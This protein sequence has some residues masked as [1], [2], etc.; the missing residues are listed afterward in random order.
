MYRN[1]IDCGN[2]Q[3][4]TWTWATWTWSTW[5]W[6][7]SFQTTCNYTSLWTYIPKCYINTDITST[8]CQKTVSV[9]GTSSSS[10]SS[11]WG[12]SCTK[13]EISKNTSTWTWLTSQITCYGNSKARRYKID[14]GNGQEIIWDGELEAWHYGTKFSWTCNYVSNDK[15]FYLPKCYVGTLSTDVPYTSSYACTAKVT[16]WWGGWGGSYCGDGVIQRPNSSG[17][18]EQCE[19][20]IDAYKKVGSFPSFCTNDCKVRFSTTPSSCTTRSCVITIPNEWE[21]IFGP[22][23][24]II[25]G[26]AMNPFREIVTT[27]YIKN[28]SS[29]DLYLDKLCVLKKSWSTLDW[30]KQCTSIGTLYPGS[31]V[32]F[33]T[34]P[35]FKWNTSTIP[36]WNSYADNMLITTIE[37]DGTLYENAYFAQELEVRVAKPSVV[38]T[39]WGTS[40]VKDSSKIADV[41][42][43]SYDE[44]KNDNKNFV[45]TS[46]SWLS[47]YSKDKV[48]TSVKDKIQAE[49][50]KYSSGS[51]NKVISWNTWIWTISS[52]SSITKSYNGIKN[53]F[54]LKWQNLSISGIP[55]T[56]KWART[57]IIEDGDLIINGNLKY[58]ENIAFVVKGGNIFIDN[59]VTGLDGIY[60]TIK[61]S[62]VWGNIEWKTIETTN[63]K[64]I[65]NGSLYWVIEDL[66]NKRTYI[67]NES[68]GQLNVGTIISFASSIFRSPAPLVSQ[69]IEEY[70]QSEKI[71]K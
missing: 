48:D 2:G 43:V 17:Q 30:V 66:I 36:A 27:P 19:K 55:T 37:H 5:T 10:S 16:L 47:S 26:H 18:Y 34:Y 58:S 39:G 53:V 62:W 46:V 12:P 38:T 60:I 33:P 59:A 8:S 44:N 22:T 24:R 63:N 52:L 64:L 15:A 69:F 28:E 7:T 41:S 57:Y 21:I 61:K 54:L 40:Y 50:T 4:F 29:Y 1:K 45:G 51:I 70:I 68:D 49:A 6:T 65:V 9:T 25:I 20:A 32:K 67:K 42:N 3:I 23:D 31:I 11:S 56:I 35:D 13:A 71:A 14:C